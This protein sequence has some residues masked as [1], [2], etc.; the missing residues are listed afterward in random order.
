MANDSNAISR[1]IAR[2]KFEA[3]PS[4][5]YRSSLRPDQGPVLN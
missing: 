1:K 5:I 3:D 4:A 2:P